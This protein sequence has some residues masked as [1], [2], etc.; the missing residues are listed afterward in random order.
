MTAKSLVKVT[1]AR[2][3]TAEK[4]VVIQFVLRLSWTTTTKYANRCSLNGNDYGG[5]VWCCKDVATESVRIW[6]PTERIVL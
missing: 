2:T 3:A 4:E 6:F 5:V 1:Y